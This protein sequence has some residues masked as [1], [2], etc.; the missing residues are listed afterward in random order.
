MHG[1]SHCRQQTLPTYLRF[2]RS[3]INLTRK[4][5][6]APGQPR[7]SPRR[8]RLVR[9]DQAS[10]APHAS[11]SC[12]WFRARTGG[13]PALRVR[14]PWSQHAQIQTADAGVERGRRLPRWPTPQ[15]GPGA[16]SLR[17]ARLGAFLKR[18][19]ATSP[20]GCESCCGQLRRWREVFAGRKRFVG[21]RPRS[22]GAERPHRKREVVGSS[23]YR[24]PQLPQS[25]TIK[26]RCLLSVRS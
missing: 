12:L 24:G 3:A 25:G 26:R 23:P 8:T 6:S 19:I 1:N 14:G 7:L 20:I 5:G 21:H 13:R 2:R 15:S 10:E 17:L 4:T 18:G 22:S 16:K 9:R 11:G